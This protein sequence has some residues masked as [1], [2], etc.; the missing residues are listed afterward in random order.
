[1]IGRYL[2]VVDYIHER[3]DWQQLV[4]YAAIGLFAVDAHASV[5]DG[6]RLVDTIEPFEPFVDHVCN[7]YA[8]LVGAS[9]AIAE[10]QARLGNDRVVVRGMVALAAAVP[11]PDPPELPEPELGDARWLPPENGPSTAFRQAFLVPSPP[12]GSLLALARLEGAEWQSRHELVDLPE[13]ATPQQR[14]KTIL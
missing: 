14:A 11:P 5:P 7:H 1:G 3:P 9:G 10:L 6:R 2:G 13:P 12:L 4:A 8:D